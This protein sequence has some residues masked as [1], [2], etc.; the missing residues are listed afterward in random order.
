MNR[1]LLEIFKQNNTIPKFHGID[2]LDLLKH[3]SELENVPEIVRMDYYYQ[4]E[5]SCLKW[6]LL[7]TGD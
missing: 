1:N 7:I 4:Y 5:K 6:V 2:M 3:L